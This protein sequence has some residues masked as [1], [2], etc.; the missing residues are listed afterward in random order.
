MT[1]ALFRNELTKILRRR[2]MLWTA[3]GV[4]LAVILALFGIAIWLHSDDPASNPSVGGGSG[5]DSVGASLGAISIIF[6]SLIGARA[7]AYDQEN[8]LVRFWAMA[9]ARRWE[10]V[11]IRVPAAWVAALAAALPAFLVGLVASVVLPAADD[12]GLTVGGI[13]AAAWFVIITVVLWGGLAVAIG[14]LLQSTGAGIA[15]ALAVAIVGSPAIQ[16][17]S[18]LWEPFAAVPLGNAQTVLAGQ[19]AGYGPVWAAIGIALVWVGAPLALAMMRAR[20]AE[21]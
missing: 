5:I 9:G 3:V 13:G 21:L 11:A 6:A 12:D 17:L 4:E 8:R 14:T 20:R 15:V 16:A 18:L 19:D 2:A 7:G 1:V 10:L